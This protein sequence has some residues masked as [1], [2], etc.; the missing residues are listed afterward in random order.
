[1]PYGSSGCGTMSSRIGSWPAP[2]TAID[3]VKT[4]QSTPWFTDAL[5]RFTLPITL[6]V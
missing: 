3:D 4:K 5:I 2:Y 6:F 1:M